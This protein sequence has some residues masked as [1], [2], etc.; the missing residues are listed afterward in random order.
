M[1][2][3]ERAILSVSDKTGIIDLARALSAKGVEILSTGGT[4]KHLTD[5]GIAV[6]P[7]SQWSGAPEI[8][9]GRVKTLTPKVFGA[10]LHDRSNAAHVE[11]VHRLGIPRVDLVVVNLYPFEATIAKEGVTLDEAIEQID[12]GGPS[13]LRA[14]AKNHKHVLPLCDPSLYGEFLHEFESGA[15]SD[16][17]RLK[18]A[19]AVFT[20]TAAYDAMI[21]QYLSSA[22]SDAL[23][24]QLEKFQDLR[25]GENPHQS[26]G[27]Y[28]PA[29][30]RPFEQLQ[31]KELS[32]NNL[33]DLDSAI[34]LATA[35]REPAIAIIKHTNPCGVA[36]RDSLADAL[37]AAIE[38]D[39]LSAFGGIIGANRPFDGETARAVADLFLEVIVA[40]AFDD[41]AKEI[42][43]KK[44]NLRLI[45]AKGV[46]SANEIRSAA[47]GLL[48]Q[49]HDRVGDR[50]AW[51]VVTERQPTDAEM[52][53]LEFAWIV[54]AHVKSNA[55]VLTRESQSVGIGAGQ[56]SR[57]DAAKVA[58]MKSILPAAGSFAASDAFFPFRDGLDILADAGVRA[59]IQPGGSVRDAEVIAA[60][61]ERGLSMVFTGE[62]HFRH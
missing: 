48:V 49:S 46:E 61:N 30:Q 6:T 56:M 39:P 23:T 15:I 37:R 19:T 16:A 36:R 45:V 25:Y 17:F 4:A 24:L 18:A 26:A 32:Y 50:T 31:G 40:P 43:A 38:A 42:F 55:I 14:A 60:A 33:L 22:S 9:G 13:M 29:G 59:V 58:I 57:V 34:K 41:E 1:Q 7:I 2:N 3:L 54:C 8:L 21:A 5:A 35:F 11:D 28:V 53:G 51:K 20:K 27:F 62:R 52:A 12:I 47:G 44:K 10:I